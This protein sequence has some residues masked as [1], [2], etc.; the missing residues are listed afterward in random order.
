[1]KAEIYLAHVGGFTSLSVNDK[2]KWKKI[3]DLQ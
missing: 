2:D 3:H 1:M